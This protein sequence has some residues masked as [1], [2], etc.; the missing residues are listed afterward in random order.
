MEGQFTGEGRD[1][2]G[3]ACQL[4]EPNFRKLGTG[5]VERR[6]RKGHSRQSGHQEEELTFIEYLSTVPSFLAHILTYF[7]IFNN[8][9]SKY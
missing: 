4:L 7:I 1:G 3:L 2:R 6:M 5:K 8:P 9:K